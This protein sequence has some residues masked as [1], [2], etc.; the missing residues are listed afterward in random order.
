MSGC[1]VTELMF[2]VPH[3]PRNTQM[4]AVPFHAATTEK[5]SS[6]FAPKSFGNSCL[7]CS[8]RRDRQH[9]PLPSKGHSLA[10]PHP[11]HSLAD[12]RNYPLQPQS[13]EGVTNTPLLFQSLKK[14]LFQEKK[15]TGTF[16]FNKA[17]LP[18][19]GCD[20]TVICWVMNVCLGFGS[21]QVHPML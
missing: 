10:C 20:V 21:E 6:A 15:N 11:V 19:L 13:A 8:L 16:L 2:H 17:E 12:L 7:G 4:D 14:G 9:I 5:H 1:N 3:R 18:L